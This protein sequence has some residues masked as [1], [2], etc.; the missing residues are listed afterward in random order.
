MGSKQSGGILKRSP[1]ECILTHWK[2][3]R[4]PPGGGIDKRTPIKYCNQWWPVYTLDDGEKW[5]LNGSL[6]YNTI[7]QLMLFC[8]REKK[9]DEVSYVNMFFT[10]QNHPEWQRACGINSAPQDPMVLALEK[11]KGKPKLKRC[12]SACSIGQRCLKL[13]GKEDEE[14]DL[15]E[16][17]SCPYH[18]PPPAL[19]LP[20]PPSSEVGDGDMGAVGAS[21]IT[22]RTRSKTKEEGGLKIV[23]PLREAVGPEGL[24]RVKVPFTHADLNSWKEVVRRYR[25]DPEDVTNSFELIIKN[26]DPN[27]ADV[28]ILLG[29]MTESEKQLILKTAR[30]HV[31]F[32]IDGGTLQ[33]TVDDHV[34]L[35]NP[36]WDPN[37]H[38]G[39]ERLVQYRNLIRTGMATA[40][41]KALNYS[42]L[43]NT[44]QGLKET[45]SDFLERLQNAMRKY[46]KMDPA[47]E[48]GRRELANLF[49]GQSTTDIRKKL[50]K[51]KSPDNRDL[52]KLTEEA[53][54]V[55]KNREDVDRSKASKLMATGTVAAVKQEGIVRK[56]SC[57]T[58][59]RG[60]GHRGRGGSRGPL[61]QN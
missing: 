60:G 4:G 33:G 37:S 15:L 11:E 40:I 30:T 20:S 18:C 21:P 24:A 23:A 38:Q 35:T 7:L 56:G 59:S 13:K 39:Y 1:L 43:Y 28:N 17:L 46:T 47:S 22:S 12:C 6:E 8:R 45:P 27:W 32:Q 10:L 50:Q 61:G 51:L 41:P 26:Q 25:D 49:L 54:R 16:P 3:I 52:E 53:W 29:A 14:M 57:G 55:F 19:P 58:R 31:Q 48:E 36:H 34:P 9:W 5:P 42:V 44:K 2:K